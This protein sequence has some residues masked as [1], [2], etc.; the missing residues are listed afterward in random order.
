MPAYQMS[1]LGGFELRRKGKV[2]RLP[3][4]KGE[5]LLA[6]LALAPQRGHARDTLTALLWGDAS[7]QSARASLRQTLFLIGKAFD[8]S[9]IETDG[10][11]VVL[12]RGTLDIDVLEFERSSANGAAEGLERAAELYRGELLAGIVVNEPSF[13]EWLVAERERL[14]ERIIEVLARLVTVYRAR[15]NADRAIQA[16]L[17]L[18]ALDPLE[19][20]AHRVLMSLYADTGR[21]AAAL[22]Q[23]QSCVEVL[24]RE[25]GAEPASETR[26]LYRDI[27]QHEPAATKVH[28]TERGMERFVSTVPAEAER[29]IDTPSPIGRSAE[30]S[31][32]NEVLDRTQRGHGSVAIIV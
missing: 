16:A 30:L 32:L 3:T 18:T 23:Y 15:G 10:R 21:R 2:V 20:D 14:R 4:R 29:P 25:L 19:E 6:Y 17:R 28:P 24:Q 1:L 7:D 27:L 26:V 22:R 11:T 13:E 8:R 31:R 12:A 5:A 9:A